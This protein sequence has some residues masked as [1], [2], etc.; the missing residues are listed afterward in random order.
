MQPLG[1]VTLE[2]KLKGR[3]T[4]GEGYQEGGFWRESSDRYRG[5]WPPSPRQPHLWS[6]TPTLF[7]ES[8]HE[9]GKRVGVEVLSPGKDPL[10]WAD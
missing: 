4:F 1:V 8:R 7:P 2:A 9:S 6:P 3:V 5:Q 10:S